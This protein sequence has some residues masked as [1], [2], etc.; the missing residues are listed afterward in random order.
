MFEVSYCDRLIIHTLINCKLNYFVQYFRSTFI[1]VANNSEAKSA[2]SNASS[3]FGVNRLPYNITFYRLIRPR[4]SRSAAVYSPQTFPWTICRLPVRT[5]VGLSSAF[6]KNDG[7]D[8]EAWRRIW[9]APFNCNQWGLYGER[10]H[11]TAPRR[12]FFPKL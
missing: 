5:S 6:W 10:V 1:F 9:G 2:S 8:P 7:S 11:G 3:N 4:R 12:G